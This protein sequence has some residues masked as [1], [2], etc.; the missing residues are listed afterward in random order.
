VREPGSK[1]ATV[2][3]G[4]GMYSYSR[5]RLFA[6]P[7]VCGMDGTMRV[8]N[9]ACMGRCFP[10]GVRKMIDLDDGDMY[11]QREVYFST[12]RSFTVMFTQPEACARS[13]ENR[14]FFRVILR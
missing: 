1:C 12:I 14:E 6:T 5:P 4:V 9:I 7:R 13:I 8:Q 3:P 11:Q 10:G 2:P